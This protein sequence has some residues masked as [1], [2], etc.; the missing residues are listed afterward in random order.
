MLFSGT[1][2]WIHREG[3]AVIGVRGRYERESIQELS[4]RQFGNY[5]FSIH[6]KRIYKFFPGCRSVDKFC[7]PGSVRSQNW[8]L[9]RILP[10]W[11]KDIIVQAVYHFYGERNSCLS[12]SNLGEAVCLEEIRQHIQRM[13]FMLTPRRNS[14]CN[15]GIVSYGGRLFINFTGKGDGAGLEQYFFRKLAS[16]G[17]Q[18]EIET[19]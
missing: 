3:K 1:F 4:I 17:Y 7:F 2:K 19:A 8:I 6:A 9:F 13:D 14:A 18:A 16:M 11:I 12:I 5:P 15:C 10:L